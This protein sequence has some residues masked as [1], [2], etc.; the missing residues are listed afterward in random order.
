[1]VGIVLATTYLLV[2]AISDLLSSYGRPIGSRISERDSLAL[3]YGRDVGIG[4]EDLR[5]QVLAERW[6]RQLELVVTLAL[7][8]QLHPEAFDVDS[9][10]VDVSFRPFTA[11]GERIGHDEPA[12]FHLY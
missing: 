8:M 11:L 6:K 5:R 1:V 7:V 9:P 10:S 12:D 4:Q 2:R 3:K